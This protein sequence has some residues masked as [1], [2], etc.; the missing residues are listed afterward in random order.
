MSQPAEMAHLREYDEAMDSALG[1]KELA[2]A[3]LEEAGHLER[4]AKRKAEEYVGMQDPR[5][6]PLLPLRHRLMCKEM[7][8]DPGM[9]GPAPDATRGK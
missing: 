8:Y 3:L 2:A 9:D 5:H 1:M 7:G 6:G 4:E